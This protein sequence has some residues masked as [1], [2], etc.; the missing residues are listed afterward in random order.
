MTLLPVIPDAYY[1]VCVLAHRL[2]VT[3]LHKR[4]SCWEFQ[5]DEHYWLA[6]NPTDI[7]RECSTGSRVSPFSIFVR[8]RDRYGDT[9]PV[10]ECCPTNC[11]LGCGCMP[12]KDEPPDSP[13]HD[14]FSGVRFRKAVEA[15]MPERK[16]DG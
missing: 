1:A 10:G 5:V 12:A 13:E 11:Y 3:D 15:A 2:G 8:Y 4:R 6:F 16:T 7:P 14:F 9:W